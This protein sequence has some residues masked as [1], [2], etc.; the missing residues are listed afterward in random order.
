MMRH[1]LIII[2]LGIAAMSLGPLTDGF[3][4]K[5]DASLKHGAPILFSPGNGTVLSV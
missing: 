1:D 4:A 5:S 3:E 2:C